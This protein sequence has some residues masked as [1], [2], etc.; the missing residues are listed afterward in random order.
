MIITIYIFI[1]IHHVY[2]SCI[3]ANIML[4]TPSPIAEH[5]LKN[6]KPEFLRKGQLSEPKVAS[7]ASLTG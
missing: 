4:N 7:L 5:P 2:T 3:A 6:P 1:Y